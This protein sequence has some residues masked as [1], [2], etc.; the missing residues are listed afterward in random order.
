VRPAGELKKPSGAKSK[1]ARGMRLRRYCTRLVVS[2]SNLSPDEP[3]PPYAGKGWKI[4]MEEFTE[5]PKQAEFYKQ[6]EKSSR[7]RLAKREL[8]IHAASLVD[9]RYVSVLLHAAI[10]LLEGSPPMRFFRGME[11]PTV[12]P[13]SKNELSKLDPDERDL[14]TNAA[15]GWWE[16]SDFCAAAYVAAKASQDIRTQYALFR[17][18]LSLTL[19]SLDSMVM[20]PKYGEESLPSSPF[21]VD[22][23]WYAHAILAA[24]GVVEE[25]G[26]TVK[27]SSSKPSMIG[28]DWNPLVKEDIEAR[29]AAAGV[30]LQKT[31]LWHQR[32]E[33]SRIEQKKP[34][35]QTGSPPWSEG[36]VRDIY[37]NVT[38]AINYVGWMRSNIAAHNLSELAAALT[39]VDVSNAQFL[40]RRLLR[41]TLGLWR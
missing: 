35:R 10:C 37:V 32:G 30:N 11:P 33:P 13:M 41:E 5:S 28:A 40:A 22:H 14:L 25:L 39:P 24:Y 19:I 1:G 26:L 16:G 8:I 18:Y 38:D 4:T 29:L 9:A 21:P 2:L 6:L 3:R 12:I 34:P 15:Q 7:V 20:H 23:V 27:A 17:F 36:P 31:L